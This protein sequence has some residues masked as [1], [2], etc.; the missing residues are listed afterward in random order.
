MIV[1]L[2]QTVYGFGICRSSKKFLARWLPAPLDG[3]MVT[4]LKHASPHLSCHAN[5]GHSRSNHT[6]VVV[7]IRQKFDPCHHVSRS[8]NILKP[9]RIDRLP[10]TSY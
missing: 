6:S 3:G 4:H 2:G 10:M 1:A 9:T 5:F 8:L 7:E